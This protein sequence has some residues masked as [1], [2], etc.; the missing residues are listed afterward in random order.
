MSIEITKDRK[1]LLLIG[2]AVSGW[3]LAFFLAVY[4]LNSRIGNDIQPF[5]EGIRIFAAKLSDEIYRKTGN[6]T[7]GFVNFTDFEGEETKLSSY[8]AQEFLCSIL[9]NKSIS[10][11]DR[12]HGV[13]TIKELKLQAMGI[14]TPMPDVKVGNIAGAKYLITGKAEYASGY[15]SI[16]IQVID[17]STDIVIVPAITNLISNE[18]AYKLSGQED[19]DQNVLFLLFSKIFDLIKNNYQ[20][21]WTAIAIPMIGWLVKL[22]RDRNV[23]NSEEMME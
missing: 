17:I 3:M 19:K 1:R 12:R 18:M 13:T 21:L 10:I 16:S 8:V 7:V 23:K 2:C 14:V 15:I 9:Q 6:N 5:D 11:V 4:L 22:R 20:W